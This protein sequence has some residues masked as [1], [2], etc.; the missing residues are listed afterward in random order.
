MKIGVWGTSRSGH[1]WVGTMVGSWFDNAE[2]VPMTNVKFEHLGEFNLGKE[3]IVI[4]VI[5][6]FKQFLA[7]SVMSYLSAH[8]RDSKW[9]E[10]LSRYIDAYRDVLNKGH[11]WSL[12]EQGKYRK[13]VTIL[14]DR[15]VEDEEYRKDICFLLG[16]RYNEDFL[17]FMPNEGGGSSFDDFEFQG[18][19]QKM[20]I[21][22][23]S[24]QIMQTEWA[25]IYTELLNEN[26]DLYV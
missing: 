3:D 5:R 4:C 20:N 12:R 2:V 24:E 21:T 7:S 6:S 23:R 1:N 10:A 18:H 15:F 13:V 9:R 14:Y 26:K 17:N 8:G 19:A 25:D 11:R 22:S 16:G